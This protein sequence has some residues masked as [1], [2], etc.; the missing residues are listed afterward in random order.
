MVKCEFFV[1]AIDIYFIA[2]LKVAGKL[3]IFEDFRNYLFKRRKIA[4][5]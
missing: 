2:F 1:S 5:I 4:Q 3:E